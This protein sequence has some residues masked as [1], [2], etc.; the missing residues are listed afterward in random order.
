MKRIA[1]AAWLETRIYLT[2]GKVILP[3][4]A[5]LTYLLLFY[6]VGPVDIVSSAVLNALALS[7][8]FVWLGISFSRAEEAVISQLIQL[9]LCGNARLIASQALPLLFAGAAATALSAAW[10]LL[11]NVASGGKFFTRALSAA[12][13]GGMALLYF[14]ASVMGGAYGS[15]FHP[16]ILRDT[17]AA[18]LIAL[19]GCLLGTFSGAIIRQIP[20]FTYIAP[21]FPPI[22]GLIS[23]FNEALS[24]A[25]PALT[26]TVIEC[27]A[28]TAAA[29]ALKTILLR[30]IRY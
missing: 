29:F 27:W 15:L 2:T 24:L 12:D 20:A 4:L 22:Y 19:T 5:L 10:P 11:K 6:S 13:V 16:R 28:Y 8:V 7:L 30:R 21:V 1:E 9:K 17:R 3:L 26:L 25:P 23:R 18:L 14:S